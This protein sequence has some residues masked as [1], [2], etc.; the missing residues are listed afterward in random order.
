VSAYSA[1]LVY[2]P[3]RPWL[4][5][6]LAALF[7]LSPAILASLYEGDMIPTFIARACTGRRGS[8]WLEAMALSK[9][10]RSSALV[11][12]SPDGPLGQHLVRRGRA[13]SGRPPPND[14]H[15]PGTHDPGCALVRTPG[16]I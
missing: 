6:A 15:W 2:S 3:N 14:A 13:C 16:R 4:D 7:I 1:L 11:G 10:G 12:P 5:A 8:E 9:R